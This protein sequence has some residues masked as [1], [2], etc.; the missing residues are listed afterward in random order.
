MQ[1]RKGMHMSLDR[2]QQ[3]SAAYAGTREID[4]GLQAHM[5]GVYNTMGL[6][7]VLTGLTAFGVSESP[8]LLNAI[9]G[10]PL[11]WVAIFAP[12]AF[13]MFGFTPGRV[14]RLAASQLKSMFVF[15]SVLMGI[16]MGSIFA[17][18]DGVSIARVFFI[19]AGTFA[20]MS[21]YGYTT[22]RDL[23]R[24]GSFLIM[25]VIGVL[26]AGLF[27]IFFQ[28][29]ALDFAVSVIGVL[30]FTGLA[31]TQTQMLKE[32]YSYAHGEEA[33]SKLAVMGAL[34]L[35]L[36]FVNLFQFLLHLMGNR[37]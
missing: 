14:A 26:F 6:G 31:A 20:A 17:H 11:K 25:G 7:L 37:E 35:Y 27:N 21:L 3:Q 13:V 1:T 22:K 18:F 34:N 9:F 33:N 36:S 28:S 2:Y 24:L 5:R 10:T 23:G 8:A 30:V 16:S 19:T 12:L 32:T 29:P 15:F 4:A